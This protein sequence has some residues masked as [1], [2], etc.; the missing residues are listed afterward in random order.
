[1]LT[2][3]RL[4]ILLLCAFY[5][6]T[7]SSINIT[8]V[9][10]L[11]AALILSAL[12]IILQNDFLSEK[13]NRIITE[14]VLDICLVASFFVPEIHF[15]LPLIASQAYSQRL[16]STGILSIVCLI[17]N[18]TH[19]VFLLLLSLAGIFL[20]YLVTRNEYLIDELKKLRDT[21]KEHAL[22]IEA[23]NR[24][25]IEKQ[26]AD[27][28]TA[29]LKERNRIAREI[30]DNV[31]HML[32]RSILQLGA[33]KIINKNENL[34]ELLEGLHETLNT[35]MTNI[36]SS[37]HDLHDE[38]LDLQAAIRE[39]TEAVDS[40]EIHLEYG[41]GLHIP[42]NIKYCFI[43]ITKEAVNN[44]LKHS[45][46]TR[47]DIVLQEHPAFYQLLI[48]DNGTVKSGKLSDGIGLTNMR[49]RV[50]ALNGNIK[51]SNESGFKILISIIKTDNELL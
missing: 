22:L 25:L 23:K 7:S 9:V 43:S 33:I 31:G 32:T 19:A 24:Q 11:L 21:S 6:L 5:Q 4:L 41:M 39:I 15:Y 13:H 30:H 2:L 34:T 40:L 1:M 10:I 8:N 20:E 46:A 17:N 51:F 12:P 48:E 35:A 36:R 3:A 42:K 45:N 28:Y 47:M 16:I 29:T 27:I 18:P 26:D 37:V 44:T 50:K 49:D 38:S 14:I